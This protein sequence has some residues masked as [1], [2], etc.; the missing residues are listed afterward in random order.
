MDPTITVTVIGGLIT[1]MSILAR[2]YKFYI[3]RTS[4][5]NVNIT[6]GLL[7]K[8]LPTNDKNAYFFINI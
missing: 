4:D 1:V 5:G 2:K 8:P 7:D 6:V 3:N